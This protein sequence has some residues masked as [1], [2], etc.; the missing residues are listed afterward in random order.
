MKR[1]E[2]MAAQTRAVQLMSEAGI[3]LSPFEVAAV[4]VADVGLG[5]LE[6]EGLELVT[7][8]NTPRYCAKELVLLPR[9]TF[10][11]HRHPPF[12]DNPGKDET[13]RCRQG[14]VWLY[15]EGPGSP[16]IQA[17][18]PQSSARYYT[19]F[20]EIELRPGDQH[21]IPHNT[22]HWFQG[23]PEGAVVSEF[24][25]ASRDEFDIFT[26]PHIRRAAQIGD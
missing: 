2:V 14:L 8:V 20:H 16:T 1:S 22:L 3:V 17:E 4:E 13:F 12:E 18:V 25:S 24:S 21:T 7:Y 11:E 5:H 23:G 15:V 6:I 10:P 19:V 9:Q 26:N